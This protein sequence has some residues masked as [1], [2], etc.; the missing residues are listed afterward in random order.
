MSFEVVLLVSSCSR[1][2][3]DSSVRKPDPMTHDLILMFWAS[4][5]MKDTSSIKGFMPE[6][7]GWFIIHKSQTE[8]RLKDIRH[9]IIPSDAE[10][11][12]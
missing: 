3:V 12:F 8:S 2:I 10:M 11:A 7:Q 4:L 1:I 5:T 9:T 6:M